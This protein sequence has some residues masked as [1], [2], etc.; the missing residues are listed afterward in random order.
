MERQV[1]VYDYYVSL[2]GLSL[3]SLNK[4]KVSVWMPFQ[5][6]SMVLIKWVLC[7]GFGIY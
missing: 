7:G 6:D 5:W 1:I 2:E 4:A 3:F